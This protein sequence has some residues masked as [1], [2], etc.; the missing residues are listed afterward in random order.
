MFVSV[1]G[2]DQNPFV[3][4]HAVEQHLK[5]HNRTYTILRP[6]FFAQNLG[7]AYRTD[8]GRC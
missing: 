8:I 3:P 5:A 2:A 1:T 4:H 7:D 6:G